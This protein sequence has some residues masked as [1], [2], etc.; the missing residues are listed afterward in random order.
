MCSD[1]LVAF[2]RLVFGAKGNWELGTGSG[3]WLKPRG[4]YSRSSDVQIETLK[5]IVFF[6]VLL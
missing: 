1:L 4:Y 5:A 2:T 3:F 6:R